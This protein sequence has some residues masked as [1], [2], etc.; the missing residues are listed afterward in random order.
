MSNYRRFRIPG[1]YYFFTL[2]T[3]RRIPIFTDDCSFLLLKK[4]FREVKRED[5]F[6]L[7]AVVVLPD[8]L[9]MVM[10]LPENDAGYSKRIAK[11]KK[12]FGDQLTLIHR[13]DADRTSG[14]RRHERGIWQ[15]RFWEH[16]I[17]DQDDLY[18][19]IHYI[20]YNPI[21]HGHVRNVID[22]KW[23]SYH[24]FLKKGFYDNGWC[25]IDYDIEIEE[26]WD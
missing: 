23:S 22:W 16:L 15:R 10:S 3:Y 13:F 2:V 4:A 11:I 1:G 5:P 25:N 9:H 20:H 8:H 7:R 19:H 12:Y 18:K 26:K 14:I 17:R 6:R 21:K 24:S